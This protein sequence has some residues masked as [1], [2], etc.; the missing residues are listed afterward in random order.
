MFLRTEEHSERVDN[1]WN[2]L[3]SVTIGRRAD[4]QTASRSGPKTESI[5]SND[6]PETSARDRAANAEKFY[7]KHFSNTECY[8]R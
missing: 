6:P 4:Y 3:S 1:V 2:D 7:Q 8:W 5:D